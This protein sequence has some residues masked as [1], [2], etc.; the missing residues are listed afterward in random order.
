MNL[1]F[2]EAIADGYALLTE[3][4]SKHV[5]QVLRMQVGET[6]HFVDGKG[7]YY[8]GVIQEPHPKKC[9]LKIEKEEQAFGKRPYSLH[10]AVAPTKNIDRFEWVLEKA[11]E[12]GIDRITP[13][14]CDR[15]ERKVTKWER[16][17]RVIVSAMK[18]SLKAYMPIL[19]EMTSF[20]NFMKQ[21]LE[22]DKLIAHCENTPRA[23]I[24]TIIK[25]Q[26]KLIVLI[27]PEGDFT[28]TEI[29]NAEANNFTSI[30]LG[31]SRLRT[32][33]AAISACNSIYYIN[34]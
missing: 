28:P 2:T 8:E 29:T 26:Q 12:F 20:K 15:S 24:N 23:E 25:P 22:G 13:L 30:S 5:I 9:L 21:D 19:D 11:T 1:F 32:E 14:L 6:I 17:N 3:A 7:G 16:S 4:E 33:T 18:Q 31:P 34:S 10:L 27:G